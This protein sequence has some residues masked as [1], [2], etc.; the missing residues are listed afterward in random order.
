MNEQL[1]FIHIINNVRP[2]KFEKEKT[3]K[4]NFR[5]IFWNP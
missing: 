2:Y 3:G 5:F 4:K 1:W